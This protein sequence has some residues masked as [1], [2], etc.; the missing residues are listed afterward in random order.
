MGAESRRNGKP[1]REAGTQSHG[2]LEVSRVTEPGK[3]VLFRRL[4]TM[5]ACLLAVAV[6]LVLVGPGTR[7]AFA[8]VAGLEDRPAPAGAPQLEVTGT[9]TS[10]VPG[11]PVTLAVRVR[12][13]ADAQAAVRVNRLTVQVSDASAGCTADNVAVSSYRWTTGGPTYEPAPG[14]SVVVPLTIAM[15]ETGSNQDA[16]QGA[17]FPTRFTVDAAAV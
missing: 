11:R 13:P 17:R 5:S 10:L 14:T 7:G 6:A 4:C 2:A 1:D 12:N 15:V 16:C 3:K 9:A 8:A